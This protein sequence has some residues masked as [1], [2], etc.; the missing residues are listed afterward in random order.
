M[1]LTSMKEMYRASKLHAALKKDSLTAR[2]HAT[3]GGVSE[4]SV[5]ELTEVCR[6]SRCT[7]QGLTWKSS[8][9]DV[10]EMVP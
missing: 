5:P 10:T 8:D 6:P 1:A 2:L 9:A 4:E 3:L 7:T